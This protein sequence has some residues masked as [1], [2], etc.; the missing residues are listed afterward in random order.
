[1]AFCS[2]DGRCTVAALHL[3]DQRDGR[4]PCIARLAAEHALLQVVRQAG[5]GLSVDG[6]EDGPGVSSGLPLE[7]VD[8]VAEYGS[9]SKLGCLRPLTTWAY[10]L[11]YSTASLRSI[12]THVH[13]SP[14]SRLPAT[15]PPSMYWKSANM[16]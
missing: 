11:M 9:Q 1:N 16:T 8:V 14:S 4:A 2:A 10:R 15:G 13:A 5:S 6:A 7:A 12:R 3:H